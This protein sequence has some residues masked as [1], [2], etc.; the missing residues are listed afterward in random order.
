MVSIGAHDLGVTAEQIGVAVISGWH[1]GLTI[2]VTD[3]DR[4]AFERYK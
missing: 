3:A 4:P 2:R 1:N